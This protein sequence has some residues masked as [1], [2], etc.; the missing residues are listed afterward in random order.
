[1]KRIGHCLC[2]AVGVRAIVSDD[3]MACH[4]QQCQRWT[5]G[6]P[7]YSVPVS[8]LEVS[9]ADQIEAYH[10]SAHGERAFCRRCGTTLWW[11]MAGKTPT[12]VAPGLFEDQS[13]LALTSEIFTD[14]RAPWQEP[15]PGATQST[16]AEELAKLDAHLA[17]EKS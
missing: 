11:T 6:G 16:E 5:G 15:V 3:L 4:C 14:R 2:G 1:M 9:G 12:T 8:E 7:L 10:H 17:K 13:G